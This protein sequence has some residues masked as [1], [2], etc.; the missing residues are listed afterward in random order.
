MN[1]SYVRLENLLDKKGLSYNK[2]FD[3]GV[4]TDH[5]RRNI[6]A[7]KSVQLEHLVSVCRYLKVGLDDI[8]KIYYDE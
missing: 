4:L 8:V 5:A 3:L 2:L 1:F 7:G 6:K